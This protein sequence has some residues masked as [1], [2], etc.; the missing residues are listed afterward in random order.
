MLVE[1]TPYVRTC[2]ITDETAI[3]Y[4][5]YIL[6]RWSN[7]MRVSS[8]SQLDAAVT[9]SIPL[10]GLTYRRFVSKYRRIIRHTWLHVFNAEADVVFMARR[11]GE[12]LIFEDVWR[13]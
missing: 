3:A 5:D 2:E 6:Q 4:S 10:T 9:R 8:L 13:L 1:R 12:Q 11:D 7:L